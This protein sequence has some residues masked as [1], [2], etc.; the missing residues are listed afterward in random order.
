M[1]TNNQ[2]HVRFSI[3]VS[4]IAKEPYLCNNSVVANETHCAI[5]MPIAMHARRCYHASVAIVKTLDKRV[6]QRILTE[7]L[8]SV[9]DY[10]SVLWCRYLKQ[11]AGIGVLFCMLNHIECVVAAE[12]CSFDVAIGHF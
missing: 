3:V 6:L 9:F 11:H 5:E 12:H 10:V 7:S 1:F 2:F 8:N 4:I